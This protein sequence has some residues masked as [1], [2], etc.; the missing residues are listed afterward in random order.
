M[1]RRAT[2]ANGAVSKRH[3]GVRG[4]QQEAK[5]VNACFIELDI[6]EYPRTWIQWFVTH[7]HK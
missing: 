3:G 6:I 1:W 5:I 4:R 2:S 7:G